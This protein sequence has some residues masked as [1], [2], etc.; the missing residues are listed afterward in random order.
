MA[1]GL[2]CLLS[3]SSLTFR[4]LECRMCNPHILLI[5]QIWLRCGIWSAAMQHVPPCSFLAS[6]QCADI[7]LLQQTEVGECPLGQLQCAD[8]RLQCIGQRRRVK[9]PLVA[10]T[11]A[12]R[13]PFYPS[14]VHYTSLHFTTSYPCFASTAYCIAMQLALHCRCSS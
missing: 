1:E 11:R 8:I 9:W 7:R 4:V 2:F 13:V 12:H 14:V 3:Y 6:L 10:V 5:A